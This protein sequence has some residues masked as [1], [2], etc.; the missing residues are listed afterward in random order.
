MQRPEPR[1]KGAG[2]NAATARAPSR[3]LAAAIHVGAVLTLARALAVAIA[4]GA[5][6][7][8]A[9]AL[10]GPAGARAGGAPHARRGGLPHARPGGLDVLPFPG[11]PDAPP[12]TRISFPTLRPS[13]I[14]A[15]AVRGS[16]S[17]WHRGRLL[18]APGDGSELVPTRPFAPGERVSVV[19]RL[20]G[21][22][23]EAALGPDPRPVALR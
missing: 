9:A 5:A 7:T 17:G 3:A 12:G 18:A 19:V 22:G 23:S 13:Q 1:G 14:A 15:I 4:T 20:R 11:T 2:R 16:R 8:L 21:A 10:S 6:L